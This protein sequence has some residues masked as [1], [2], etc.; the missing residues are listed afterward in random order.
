MEEFVS[1]SSKDSSLLT[2]PCPDVWISKARSYSD[3]SIFK[4]I[5]DN[6]R[7][8]AKTE[9][10]TCRLSPTLSLKASGSIDARDRTRSTLQP[11]R[12]TSRPRSPFS[13]EKALDLLSKFA[14][15]DFVAKVTLSSPK[16]L[17]RRKRSRGK[18]ENESR[19][20]VS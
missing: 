3:T 18:A 13:A 19:E 20:S 16:L 1:R 10:D 9:D 4:A 12:K 2:V 8:Y 11:K 6:S 5:S 17:P 14:K 7:S 15:N